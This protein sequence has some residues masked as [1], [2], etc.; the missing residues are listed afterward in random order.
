MINLIIVRHGKTDWNEKQLMQGRT[1]IP[2]NKTGINDALVLSNLI[3]EK[4]IDICLC[5]PLIRA[6]QT[7]D[8]ITQNTQ[9]IIDELLVERGFGKL[10]GEKINFDQ[11]YLFWNYNLNYNEM[12]VESIQS[13]LKRAKDFLEKIKQQYNDKTILIVSHGAFIKALHYN[14]IGYDEETDFL[15]FNPQNTK[16]YYYTLK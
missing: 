12:G 9:I 10:E 2:L 8:L 5:S 7:A 6:K 11:I 13:C 4:D 1:D 3:D 14:L 16:P 15:S